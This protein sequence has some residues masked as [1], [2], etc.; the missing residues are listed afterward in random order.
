MSLRYG[1]VRYSDEFKSQVLKLQ[2]HHWGPDLALNAAYL[3]W[4]YEDNPYVKTPLTYLALWEGDVVGMR[5]LC[6]ARWEIGSSGQAVSV[7]CASDLVIA[8]AHRNRGLLNTM[9]MTALKDL[10]NSDYR[11]V[12]NLSP[13]PVTYLSFLAMGWRSIGPLET[14]RWQA[15]GGTILRWLL[16]HGQTLRHF[17]PSSRRLRTEA[18]RETAPSLA[19]ACRTFSSL[20]ANRGGEARA[21]SPHVSVHQRPRPEAMAELIARIGSDGRM[22]HVR[23]AQYFGW[24][25][26][27][28][29][30]IY[31]FL[32]WEGTRLEGYLV[33]RTRVHAVRK[34][35]SIVDW[36]ATNG[37]VREDLLRAAIR[38]GDFAQVDIWSATH[39]GEVKILLERTGFRRVNEPK[40]VAQPRPAVL[41]RAVSDQMQSSQWRVADRWLLDLTN[42][43]LRMIYSDGS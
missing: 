8:P 11:Y 41:I 19:G 38:W 1:I 29:K 42:W 7:L 22:R 32:L 5:G 4:K 35:V 2:A 12:F 33:L 3:E 15:T 16:G 39:A 40:G 23:D 30:S 18:K 28:P 34:I 13:S 37:Q 43:D 27:N 26:R 21:V 9:T 17:Y 36:E 14:M 24:R 6:G 10:V 31:R 25:F 20:D